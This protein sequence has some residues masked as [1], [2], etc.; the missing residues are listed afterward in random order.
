[1]KSL[2][3]LTLFYTS[4]L[5]GQ[6][7]APLLTFPLQADTLMKGVAMESAMQVAASAGAEISLDIM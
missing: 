2:L 4:L 6:E 1:M 5:V 3:L 7:N